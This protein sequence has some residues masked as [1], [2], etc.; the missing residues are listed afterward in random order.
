VRLIA[1]CDGFHGI[2]RATVPAD[3]P[4]PVRA[5][6]PFA[7]LGILAQ[8]PPASHEVIYANDEARFALLSMRSPTMSRLYVQCAPEEDVERGQTSG[9]GASCVHASTSAG[10]RTVLQ[11]VGNPHA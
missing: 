1:G 10:Q 7:W 6:Y 11:K 9:S 2:C 8:T 3:P 5:V 4:Q